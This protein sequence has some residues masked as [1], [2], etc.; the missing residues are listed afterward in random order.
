MI[1]VLF[2]YVGKYIKKSQ[3]YH[4]I[5]QERLGMILSTLFLANSQRTCHIRCI[6]VDSA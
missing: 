5:F 6:H 2:I 3:R 1:N 4:W